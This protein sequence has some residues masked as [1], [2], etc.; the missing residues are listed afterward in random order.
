MEITVKP[1]HL[2]GNSFMN[3]HKRSKCPLWETLESEGYNVRRVGTEDLALDNHGYKT[4]SISPKW[5]A[6]TVAQYIEEA[7]G[8]DGKEIKVLLTLVN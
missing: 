3:G 8:G 6:R 1:E 2:I 5:N 4:Y 7:E